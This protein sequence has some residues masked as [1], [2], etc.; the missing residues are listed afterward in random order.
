MSR[1][2][3]KNG[4]P[5]T[6]A[7]S[8]D[9]TQGR[10]RSVTGGGNTPVSLPSRNELTPQ[11]NRGRNSDPDV[12]RLSRSS[13]HPKEDVASS[14]KGSVI[15]G[16]NTPLAPVPKD[17]LS[18]E[19]VM[20]SD[21]D[22]PRQSRNNGRVTGE[23]IAPPQPR[24]VNPPR[25]EPRHSSLSQRSPL[26]NSSFLDEHLMISNSR[27]DSTLLRMFS[28]EQYPR[29]GALATPSMAGAYQSDDISMAPVMWRVHPMDPIHKET[30]EREMSYIAD[31]VY[32]MDI[33]G[34]LCRSNVLTNT[35]YKQLNRIEGQGDRAVTRLMVK[36][37]QRRGQNAYPAFLQVLQSRGYLSICE[38]LLESERSL[39][40]G[41]RSER[42]LTDWESLSRTTPSSFQTLPTFR[43]RQSPLTSDYNNY[44][45]HSSLPLSLFSAGYNSSLSHP[46]PL[47]IPLSPPDYPLVTNQGMN[48]SGRL[49]PLIQEPAKLNHIERQLDTLKD[50]LKYLHEDMHDLKSALRQG[51]RD[52]LTDDIK[53][54][55]RPSDSTPP[56]QSVK[57]Q[58]PNPPQRTV[59]PK[60]EHIINTPAPGDHE[61]PGPEE[62]TVMLSPEQLKAYKVIEAQQLNRHLRDLQEEVKALHDDVTALST[63]RSI[64][65]GRKT[66]SDWSMVG[67]ELEEAPSEILTS[68]TGQIPATSEVHDTSTDRPTDRHA[69]MVPFSSAPRRTTHRDCDP[70]PN[71]WS[72][73]ANTQ[74]RGKSQPWTEPEVKRA[75][76]KNATSRV[77]HESHDPL[78]RESKSSLL[79]SLT[80]D[81]NDLVTSGSPRS[82]HAPK[83]SSTG[84]INETN[85]S[86]DKVPQQKLNTTFKQ[87]HIHGQPDTWDDIQFKPHTK[88]KPVNK[89][90]TNKK[91]GSEPL[92]SSTSIA[93]SKVEQLQNPRKSK[94]D[95]SLLLDKTASASLDNTNNNLKTKSTNKGVKA[96][97]EKENKAD[98][99]VQKNETLSTKHQ[100]IVADK[101]SSDVL[102][103]GDY[104]TTRETNKKAEAGKIP[105][106]SHK[107]SLIKKKVNDE[108]SGYYGQDLSHAQEKLSA[109]DK[110]KQPRRTLVATNLNETHFPLETSKEESYAPLGYITSDLQQKM[111]T[112]K[113]DIAALRAQKH[114]TPR[115]QTDSSRD[116]ENQAHKL[117]KQ[118]GELYG[119]LRTL[120]GDVS[121]LKSEKQKK[122]SITEPLESPRKPVTTKQNPDPATQGRPATRQSNPVNK[123]NVPENSRKS[124]P[125]Y[126][127]P[128]E[129]PPTT[130]EPNSEGDRIEVTSSGIRI[131]TPYEIL[132]P[133][134]EG[135]T[136]AKRITSPLTVLPDHSLPWPEA[137]RV[138]V[139]S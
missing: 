119:Q 110:N 121:Q 43:K 78:P 46:I 49:S 64:K 52:R 67:E 22:L 80:F 53:R 114:D 90:G 1:E 75:K 62:M 30:L 39:K 51:N 41:M 99:D 17:D 123:Q 108:N 124:S 94:W 139:S 23:R 85:S 104:N 63:S 117:E 10:R 92:N 15:S 40:F 6:R 9:D 42:P 29:G 115:S 137:T 56:D 4:R 19:E 26:V 60:Q 11:D 55:E 44:P 73:Q 33:L 38:R 13:S 54:P 76:T 74:K 18:P 21:P 16:G 89:H 57:E 81:D 12:A 109:Q 20:N 71:P 91:T 87:K 136:R 113:D 37:L 95:N 7:V 125:I 47:T 131:T 79:G 100:N 31:N 48:F 133:P 72:V 34:D 126:L 116:Q 135:G 129:D 83:E 105:E 50:E 3:S 25:F 27:L 66:R 77:T 112:L 45:L 14:R 103:A 127:S 128:Q 70:L 130:P 93:T 58:H 61:Q 35:D 134:A 101:T 2:Q 69:S 59:S 98:K 86:V 32:P 106:Q 88:T 65:D 24:N 97:H 120:R 138:R 36:T 8:F 5:E 132:G 107:V 118:L 122:V 111:K 28:Q 82:R 68:R 84:E 96:M 102:T